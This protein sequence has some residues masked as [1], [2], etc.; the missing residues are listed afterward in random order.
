MC[1]IRSSQVFPGTHCTPL[2]CSVWSSEI[3]FLPFPLGAPNTPFV[4]SPLPSSS[5]IL[6]WSITR[7]GYFPVGLS[8]NLYLAHPGPV[9][10]PPNTIWGWF[11]CH[12]GRCWLHSSDLWA[13]TM[14]GQR[15]ARR[16]AASSNCL[17]FQSPM[18][19]S[20]DHPFPWDSDMHSAYF[21]IYRHWPFQRNCR[22]FFLMHRVA[23][24]V[25]S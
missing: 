15:P 17:N 22:A 24:T 13:H 1:G 23:S 16:R 14:W 12:P 11:H 18:S 21:D 2:A 7:S 9:Q 3:T 10:S 25:H 19:A 6:P 20:S 4:I 5:Y 8:G